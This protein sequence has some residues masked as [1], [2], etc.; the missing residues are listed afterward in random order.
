[1]N[2]LLNTQIKLINRDN[3]LKQK[4]YSSMIEERLG[5]TVLNTRSPVNKFQISVDTESQISDM[6]MYS[7]V[8][9]SPN[10]NSNM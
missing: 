8:L 5:V 3:D 2:Y 10:E 9:E 6:R 4:F 7:K 1:M